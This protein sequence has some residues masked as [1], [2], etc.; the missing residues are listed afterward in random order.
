LDLNAVVPVARDVADTV[1]EAHFRKQTEPRQG[2]NQT[3]LGTTAGITTAARIEIVPQL[4]V[5][6]RGA[7]ARETRL[8]RIAAHEWENGLSPV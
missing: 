7:I 4:S 1:S 5:R 8:V 3:P 6:C 2:Q